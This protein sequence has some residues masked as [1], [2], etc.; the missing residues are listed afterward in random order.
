MANVNL[1]S[2]NKNLE[3]LVKSDL[4]DQTSTKPPD[5]DD[6]VD[7]EGEEFEK[8]NSEP[9]TQEQRE[10]IHNLFTLLGDKVDPQMLHWFR[11]LRDLTKVEAEQ[12]ISSLRAMKNKTFSEEITRRLLYHI[13]K[14][15]VSAIDTQTPKE[16]CEDKELVGEMTAIIGGISSKLG[17][18]KALFMWSIYII[19]SHMTN[20]NLAYQ[21]KY[22]SRTDF[23]N[24]GTTS[25]AT[26]S[27]PNAS[28]QPVRVRQNNPDD[29]TTK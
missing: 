18:A 27:V 29:K 22:T 28:G 24:D 12:Y 10:L 21:S 6:G 13:T 9:C 16:V 26:G 7:E 23:T 14:A 5:F 1:K 4:P 2:V 3:N 20:W 8:E 17:K 25:F 15:S 19:S 11:N